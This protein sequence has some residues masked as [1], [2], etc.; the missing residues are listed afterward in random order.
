MKNF[1]L[2]LTGIAAA[3]VCIVATRPRRA[4]RSLDDLAHDL[5]GAWADHHTVV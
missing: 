4:Q 1:L 3:A 5:Q 2:L